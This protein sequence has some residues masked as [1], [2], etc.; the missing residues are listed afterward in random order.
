MMI[1][2]K[3]KIENFRSIENATVEIDNL[4]ALVG[5]NGCGKSTVLNA[6]LLF[7]SQHQ[8]GSSSTSI[9]T[10]D[11]YNHDTS[12]EICIT[13]TFSSLNDNERERF[14]DYVQD[15]LLSITRVFDSGGNSKLHG[16]KRMHRG[17]KIIRNA[18]SAA[19]KRSLYSE[20]RS[21]NPKYS[22]LP[23]WKNKDVFEVAL[24]EWEKEYPDECTF[25]RDDGAFFGYGNVGK[26]KLDSSTRFI[27]VPAVRDAS[28]DA[29]DTARSAI[30]T[31]LEMVVRKRLREREDIKKL[32]DKINAEYQGLIEPTREELGMLG[33]ELT[34]TLRKLIPLAEVHLDW[35]DP[36]DMKLPMPTAE[37]KV[38]EDAFLCNLSHVGHGLQRAFIITLLQ[39]LAFQNE[40]TN[41]EDQTDATVELPNLVLAIEEP[42]L[43]QHPNRQRHLATI[44]HKIATGEVTGITKKTQII[45][46]THSPLMVGLDR[47]DKLRLL[48]K[49]HTEAEKPSATTIKSITLKEVAE[50]LKEATKSETDFTSDS[51]R[52]RLTAIMNSTVNEGFF[53][54]VN[55]L[56]EG[57]DDRAAI[58]GAAKLSEKDLDGKGISVLPVGGKNNLDR[59]YLIFTSF[60][61][62]CYMVWDNDRGKG[63][64][65]AQKKSADTNKLLQR[66]LGV[67]EEDWPSETNNKY[68]CLDKNLE[69]LLCDDIPKYQELMEELKDQYGYTKNKNALKS[70][71]LIS[72]LLNRSRQQ[73]SEITEI[74][75][76]VDYA[77]EMIE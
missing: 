8:K 47:F 1:L 66:L 11:F 32:E 30:G 6:L 29:S 24:Q 54:Q 4:T 42:E 28:D 22:M 12:K 43:Y 39:H 63:D 18:S 51:L 65:S 25:D 77:L 58:L 64:A 3:V 20:I 41:T 16:S 2:Q 73:G 14:G 53:S 38:S 46:S 15:N 13:C 48:R 44:L 34:S 61:I 72:E 21:D 50:K 57:E 56:V 67:T 59:L 45:Y 9:T 37:V 69:T 5:A 71:Y 19:E 33:N 55:I 68:C 40:N 36:K 35:N 75:Q 70:P 26:G 49:I 74:H 31:L 7:Y 76:I 60:G 10:Q 62:P 23:S 27:M 52:S 17:F